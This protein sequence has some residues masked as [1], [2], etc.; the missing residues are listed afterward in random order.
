MVPEGGSGANPTAAHG[1]GGGT[2]GTVEF[3][4]HVPNCLELRPRHWLRPHRCGSLDVK[5]PCLMVPE[6]VDLEA[7]PTAAHGGGGGTER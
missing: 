4:L 1:G 6:R 3:E 2:N 7:N 5:I